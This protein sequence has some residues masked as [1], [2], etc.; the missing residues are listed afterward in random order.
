MAGVTDTRLIYDIDTFGGQSGSPIWQQTAEAGL[1][2]VGIHTTG[3]VSSNS[4]TR[5]TAD[6]LGNLVKWTTE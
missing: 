3:G 1:I 6:V 4:G 5:I 2:A